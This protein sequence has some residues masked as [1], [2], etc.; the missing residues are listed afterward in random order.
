MVDSDASRF[1]EAIKL[2]LAE[3][4]RYLEFPLGGTTAIPMDSEQRLLASID[5]EFPIVPDDVAALRGELSRHNAY[6]LVTFATRMA[7]FV[8]RTNAASLM[9]AVSIGLVLDDGLVDW[10]DMLVALSIVEDC[11][12]RLGVDF[13]ACI[14]RTSTL[15]ADQR[16]RTI[17]QGYL[18]RE[19][20][21]R[22]IGVMGFR[23]E[24]VGEGLHYI[25]RR[26][27]G[28]GFS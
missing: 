9:E 18:T 15:A 8:A 17:Q 7:V 1:C 13:R 27:L 5:Q 4:P 11:A 23:T 2:F 22:D 28:T 25:R 3:Y 20:K 24:G 14:D 10:R 12:N 6:S 26:H 19:P 21:M 16:R